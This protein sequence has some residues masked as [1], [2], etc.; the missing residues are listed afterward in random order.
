MMRIL[1]YAMSFVAVLTLG[2]WAYRENYATQAAQR[3]VAHLQSEIATLRESIA[4]QRAEWA[5][6]NRPDR[7]RELVN[8]NFGALQLQPMQPSQFGVIDQIAYPAPP[9]LADLVTGEVFDT[10]GELPVVGE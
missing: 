7:L 4:V 3:E 1:L 2:F 10:I 6:L 5:Y 9:S 8:T